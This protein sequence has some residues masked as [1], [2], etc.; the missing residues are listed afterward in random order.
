MTC[1]L[2]SLLDD[3]CIMY[4]WYLFFFYEEIV[5]KIIKPKLHDEIGLLNSNYLSMFLSMTANAVIIY[6]NN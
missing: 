2:F 3:V 4:G 6:D 1:Y 5:K